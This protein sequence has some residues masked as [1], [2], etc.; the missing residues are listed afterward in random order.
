MADIKDK[1]TTPSGGKIPVPDLPPRILLDLRTDC[2][3]KC[4][5]C[6]VHGEAADPR[7]QTF[8][9]RSMS[10][11]NARRILDEVAVAKPL[12]KPLLWSEPLLAKDF[13]EHVKAMKD[14]GMAVAIDTNGLLM[15]EDLARFLVDI[16]FDCV[17]ISIDA[18]TPETLLKVRGIDKLDKIHRAVEMMLDARGDRTKPRIGVSFTVQDTNRH[19]QDD[20]VAAW[21]Q[22][23]DF[24]R[25]GELFADGTFPGVV[26]EGERVACDALY[27]TMVIHTNGDVSICCLDAFAEN[28]VG[29]VLEQ[30]VKEVWHGE[31]LTKIRHLHETGQGDKVPFCTNCTRWAS[32]DYAEE[33]RDGLLIRRSVEYTYYN[34]IDRLEN[35]QGSLVAFHTPGQGEAGNG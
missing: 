10:L 14:R 33:V 7:L 32:Y 6:I 18:V 2:N 21:S 1:K 17:T 5:M 34:R 29:N 12:V 15:R 4:P 28:V 20:F 22:R 19:E 23:V 9:R 35:W 25:V 31:K 24:V 8:L 30:G 26:P 11:E 16:E 27:N 3:L 13:R